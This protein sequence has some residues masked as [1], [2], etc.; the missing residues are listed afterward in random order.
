V[1]PKPALSVVELAALLFSVAILVAAIISYILNMPNHW[2]FAW[3]RLRNVFLGLRIFVIVLQWVPALQGIFTRYFLQRVEN[4]FGTSD[5]VI[6]C[7]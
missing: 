6:S 5:N 2:R 1:T 4:M 3:S 7:Q